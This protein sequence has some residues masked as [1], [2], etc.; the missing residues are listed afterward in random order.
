[1]SNL[2]K[3]GRMLP[4]RI[5]TWG[6]IDL[7]YMFG[8]IWGNYTSLLFIHARSR[9]GRSHNQGESG[10]E[11]S[12]HTTIGTI[13]RSHPRFGMEMLEIPGDIWGFPSA[14]AIKTEKKRGK[15]GLFT[16]AYWKTAKTF[17][18]EEHHHHHHHHHHQ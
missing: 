10:Q 16:L 4:Q 12:W 18:P 2:E 7:F 3:D 8:I 5:H 9:H 13:S 11:L 17:L 14:K 6:I 15:L 1:M